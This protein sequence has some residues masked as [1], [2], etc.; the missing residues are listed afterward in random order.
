MITGCVTINRTGVYIYNAQC[1]KDISI[2]L[3]VQS[4]FRNPNSDGKGGYA[5]KSW[6]A[7]TKKEDNVMYLSAK[8]ITN[9]KSK[10]RQKY[11]QALSAIAPDLCKLIIQ[12][13]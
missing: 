10:T 13:F 2:Q 3:F 6:P 1:D 9:N 8:Q 4:H 5:D 7:Q 12:N 11:C